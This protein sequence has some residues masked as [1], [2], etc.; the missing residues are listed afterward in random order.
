MVDEHGDPIY[1]TRVT[2]TAEFG[3]TDREEELYQ[4]TTDYLK[5]YYNR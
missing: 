2:K 1:P 3:L 5:E 4:Q